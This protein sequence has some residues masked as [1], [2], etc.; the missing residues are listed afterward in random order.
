[1]IRRKKNEDV[2][3]QLG[4][5]LPLPYKVNE[6]SALNKESGKDPIV[7]DSLYK[8]HDMEMLRSLQVE[9]DKEEQSPTFSK[10]IQLIRQRPNP[11]RREFVE[12]LRDIELINSL[13]SDLEYIKELII[14]KRLS[15][16]DIQLLQDMKSQIESQLLNPPQDV[17]FTNPESNGI[18]QIS[19]VMAELERLQN[20]TNLDFSSTFSNESSLPVE[21]YKKRLFEIPIQKILLILLCTIVFLSIPYVLGLSSYDYCYY[22]C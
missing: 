3:A 22:F 7:A 8:R 10:P 21:T 9:V 19:P 11:I 6:S 14:S 17:S 18:N 20:K 16:K 5:P 2:I 13:E 12:K 15:T 4:E 1:M